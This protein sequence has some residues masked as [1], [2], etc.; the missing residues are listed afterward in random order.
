MDKELE[1]I[2]KIN[3]QAIDHGS[4][5]ITNGKISYLLP[6]VMSNDCRD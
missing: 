1:D 5:K 6:V 4:Y 3:K 2:R